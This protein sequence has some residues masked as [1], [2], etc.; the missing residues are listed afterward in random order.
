M[1]ALGCAAI[2]TTRTPMRT[3]IDAIV[4]PLQHAE[5]IDAALRAVVPHAVVDCLVLAWHYDHLFYQSH[6]H[7]KRYH[8]RARELW[9]T[10]AAGRLHKEL[11]TLQALVFDKLDSIVRASSLV[12]M[13]NG[14]MRPYRKSCKGQI[15]QE[16]FNLIMFDHNPHR[17][18]SGKRQGKAPV[19]LLTGKP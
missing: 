4:V 19:A 2:T 10:C 15:T 3:H 18:K 5:A 9:L 12:E 13:V 6:A 1:E 7:P 16:A 17:D 8:H 14:L 11:D